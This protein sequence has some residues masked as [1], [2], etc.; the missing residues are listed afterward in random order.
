MAKNNDMAGA[1]YKALKG[2]TAAEWNKKTFSE[3]NEFIQ[4]I[5]GGDGADLPA[6]FH[7]FIQVAT[8][9]VHQ[10][11]EQEFREFVNDGSFPPIKLTPQEMGVLQGGASIW[12]SF[13]SGH[14]SG[15]GGKGG[16]CSRCSC[17]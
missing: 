5:T 8:K 16:S 11:S 10:T 14:S 15:K 9:V 13:I 12:D 2:L 3:K 7:E 1:F 4:S 6:S 17:P